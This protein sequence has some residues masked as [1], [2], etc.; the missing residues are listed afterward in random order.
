MTKKEFEE[1]IEIAK[2]RVFVGEYSC[3]AVRQELLDGASYPY[4]EGIYFNFYNDGLE[5]DDFNRVFY[6]MPW[7]NKRDLRVDL[8]TLYGE[9]L[10]SEEI[11][12]AL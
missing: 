1:R 4:T 11:Y 10:K 7:E 8:I 2:L 5:G 12:H 9:F 6:K 3:I